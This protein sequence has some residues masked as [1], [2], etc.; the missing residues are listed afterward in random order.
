M[1]RKPRMVVPHLPHHVVIRGNNRRRLFS[2]RLD[3]ETF[4]RF[5]HQAL[6][7]TGCA[8]NALSIMTNHVH[9][10]LTPSTELALPACIKLASQR[11]A[12]FRNLRRGATG[13]LYEQRYFCKLVDTERYLACVTAYIDANPHASGLV[14]WHGAAYPFTTRHLH[15]GRVD[16]G[17]I[18][19]Q[20]WTPSAWYVALGRSDD[21]RA[22][23]YAQVAEGY[24][25]EALSIPNI[26]AWKRPASSLALIGVPTQRQRFERP[27]GTTAL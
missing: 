24:A 19:P 6:D 1:A 4:L 3:Y 21:E 23:A 5:L 20:I 15:L 8:L 7:K 14:T 2:S 10:L 26:E 17:A 18:S 9:L 25:V 13:K 12:Y 11:Y 22:M 27:D 16:V